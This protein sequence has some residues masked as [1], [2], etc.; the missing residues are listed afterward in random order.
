M[1]NSYKLPCVVAA[2][3]ALSVAGSCTKE[4]M[5]SVGTDAYCPAMPVKI[6]AI[7]PG[8]LESTT[9]A[10]MDPA[11]SKIYWE[12]GDKILVND[13]ILSTSGSSTNMADFSGAV[14]GISSTGNYVNYY[15]LYPTSISTGAIT[16]NIVQFT[17]PEVQKHHSGKMDS[18]YM[19]AH[20]RILSSESSMTLNFKNL[21]SVM[22][23]TLS[24]DPTEPC[25]SISKI[26]I[27]SDKSI[28][29]IFKA[30]FLASSNGDAPA[31]TGSSNSSTNQVTID[32][33]SGVNISS[34][35]DFH[36]MLPPMNNG[37]LS[38]QIFGTN[39]KYMK[40]TLSGQTLE[41]NYAYSSTISNIVFDEVVGFSVS[42][43]KKV[44]FAP[45]NLQYNAT[46]TGTNVHYATCDERTVQGYFRFAEH[47]WEMV[48]ND[49]VGNVSR[50]DGEKCDNSNISNTYAGWID[51]FGFGTTGFDNTSNDVSATNF[52]PYSST[53]SDVNYGPSGISSESDLSG[54]YLKYDWGYYCTIYN[55]KTKSNDAP[56]TWR[57][58][59]K[60]EWNYLIS[61]R[62]VTKKAWSV[63][64]G[65]YGLILLPDEFFDPRTSEGHKAFTHGTGS[66]K[67]TYSADNWRQMENAGAV[68][69]P[70]AGIRSATTISDVNTEGNYHS[71]TIK[72]STSAYVTGFS[73]SSVATDKECGRSSGCSVRLVKDVD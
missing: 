8:P 16:S 73:S 37:K 15:A 51:L 7:S 48:G 44:V 70:A 47:Q 58:P 6:A 31:I 4:E 34:P 30:T 22:N 11:D 50:E 56:G 69:L 66:V 12:N 2:V 62:S 10:Y 67:N 60:S 20:A 55:P 26:V 24:A 71:S 41:R 17:L 46:G 14:S 65:V 19:A 61:T 59:T 35:T 42:S 29:G 64:N 25:K 40:K 38:V 32:C 1:R 63:V 52:M 39:G 68:F 57:L 21:T 54:T 43:S 36:V 23:L 9:K 13:N 18:N 5:E 3:V 49:V 45:G 72:G 53:V 33:G 28:A 27:T